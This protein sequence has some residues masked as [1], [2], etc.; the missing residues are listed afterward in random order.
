MPQVYRVDVGLSKG[1]GDG[2]PQALEILNDHVVRV[3][4]ADT[5]G[6][7]YGQYLSCTCLVP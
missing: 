6:G 7:I 2:E 5:T 4:T 3:I 1:C